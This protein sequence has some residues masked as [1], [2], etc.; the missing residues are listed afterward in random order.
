MRLNVQGCDLE[1]TM[2]FQ[3]FGLC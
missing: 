1:P 3:G 2:Q